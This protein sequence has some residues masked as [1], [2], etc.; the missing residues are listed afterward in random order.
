[1]AT[2][3]AKPKQLALTLSEDEM[4]MLKE[5][6]EAE[7]DS[8]A[9]TVRAL[10]RAAYAKRFKFKLPGATLMPTLR[11]LIEQIARPVPHYTGGN[12]A[13]MAGLQVDLVTQ[14]LEHVE[15]RTGVVGQDRCRFLTA[16]ERLSPGG[17]PSQNREK[18]NARV[19]EETGACFPA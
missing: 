8:A 18:H 3:E 15:K 12:I 19:M 10:I 5:L 13:E 2:S 7:N 4:G 14:L 6:A 11:A 9:A 17:G 1:M 16:P